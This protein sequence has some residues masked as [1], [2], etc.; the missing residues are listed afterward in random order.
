MRYAPPSTTAVDTAAPP[1]QFLDADGCGRRYGF[2]AAHWRRQVD[3]GKAPQPTR[4]GRLCRWSVV[5]LDQWDADGCPPVR[6]AKR[7][8]G[9]R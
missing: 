4:F 2:S 5:A 3:A 9:A 6:I 1:P 8:G 7:Q